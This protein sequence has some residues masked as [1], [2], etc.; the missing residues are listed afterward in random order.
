MKGR[1]FTLALLVA[2][3]TG[4]HLT[5]RRLSESFHRL[6][7]TSDV[8]PLPSPEQTVVLSLG[9]RA[10]LADLIYGHV[11]VSYGLHFEEKRLF[12][13]AGNYLSTINELDPKFR[14]PYLFAD[15]LL[16]LQP[17]APPLEHYRAARK[18]LLRGTRERP[19]DTRLWINAGQF[20]A[21]L[22]RPYLEDPKEK[23]A[24]KLEGA[25]LLARGCELVGSDENLPYNCITAAGILNRTGQHDANIRFLRRFL[26]VSDDPEIR[27]TAIAMLRKELARQ[28]LETREL[29]SRRL[30]EERSEK[31]G[32]VSK[33]MALVLAP[34]FDPVDCASA[35]GDQ[36]HCATS[37]RDWAERG[38][39]ESLW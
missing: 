20:M 8:Y 25:R 34:W 3:A 24:W 33:D 7:V 39:T 1:W 11:L 26:A 27:R 21:Y 36:R 38:E 18:I 12:E 22:A 30:D 14:E 2:C 16:V 37:W 35:T 29:R 5:Q 15:T 28:G 13:F 32:F 31:L 6:R 9:Y 23:Q 19:Y 4:V 17:K 10:A